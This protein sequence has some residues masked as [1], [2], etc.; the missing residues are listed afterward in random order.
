[1]LQLKE[2]CAPSSITSWSRRWPSNNISFHLVDTVVKLTMFSSSESKNLIIL[3]YSPLGHKVLN[4]VLYI[5]TFII[6]KSPVREQIS[7][8]SIASALASV[9][10][11]SVSLFDLPPNRTLQIG[12]SVTF[13]TV[14][15][16]P[17]FLF[18]WTVKRSYLLGS[19]NISSKLNNRTHHSS[20]NFSQ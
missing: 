11:W 3:M 13:I 10:R 6:L 9:F 16:E 1:M 8:I 2:N 20:R 4:V 18:R 17:E 7:N 5:V 19:Q 15:Y 14:K 12:M